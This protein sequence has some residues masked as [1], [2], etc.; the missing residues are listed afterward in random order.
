MILNLVFLFHSTV[1]YWDEGIGQLKRNLNTSICKT[2]GRVPFEL[3]YGYIPR[4]NE[5]FARELTK[6]TENY[7]I[8]E[9]IREAVRS[10]VDRKQKAAEMRYDRSRLKNVKYAAGD[11][12]VVEAVR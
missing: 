2:T 3:L 12:V 6:R 8:P 10:K 1:R 5:G 7:R 11:I 9:E 4:F